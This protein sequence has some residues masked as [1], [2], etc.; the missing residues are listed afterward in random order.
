[1]RRSLGPALLRP[2]LLTLT[3]T[4]A[5]AGCS[6]TEDEADGPDPSASASASTS[7]TP[8]PTPSLDVPAGV[9]LTTQGTAL[10]LGDT[11][12][13]AYEVDQSTVGV[14]DITVTDMRSTTFKESF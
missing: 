12:T 2:V 11:A 13:V 10:E 9:E 5:L 1:M 4:L 6:G 3:A 7:A 8:E 14:L